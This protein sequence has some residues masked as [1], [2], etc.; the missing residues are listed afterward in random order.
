MAVQKKQEA[1]TEE[2]ETKKEIIADDVV[3]K[4][5]GNVEIIEEAPKEK[6]E[7]KKPEE[8][9]PAQDPLT[10]FKEK[11]IRE[12]DAGFE[13]STKKNYM[14][15]I[16]LVFVIMIILFVGV[17]FYKQ[18]GITIGNG[19]TNTTEA[20][21]SPTVAPEPTTEEVDLAKYEIEVQNGSGV[22]GEASRQKDALEEEGFVVASIDNADNS[23]YTDTIIKAKEDVDEDYLEKLK[24][25]LGESFTV[26]EIETLSEDA[27]ASVVIIIGAENE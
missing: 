16:L 27:S 9:V 6:P 15:P 10:E 8:A 20:T 18:G 25:F 4:T 17:F 24:D 23:D 21:V 26:G 5:T 14:W 3:V 12:E 7:E 2:V 11:M 19:E 22:A 1:K 13:A